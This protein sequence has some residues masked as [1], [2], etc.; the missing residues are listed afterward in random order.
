[1]RN[2]LKLAGVYTLFAIGI[3]G[4]LSAQSR[5]ER[6]AVQHGWLFDY[7]QARARAAE[8]GRPLMVVF[9]CVP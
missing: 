4:D 5:Q 6:A 2:S 7:E 8:T 3:C 9:R 1:M